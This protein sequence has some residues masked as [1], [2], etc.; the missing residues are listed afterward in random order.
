MSSKLRCAA[1]FVC[2]LVTLS[3]FKSGTRLCTAGEN[4]LSVLNPLC[5]VFVCVPV[6]APMCRGFRIQV[7]CAGTDFPLKMDS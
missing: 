2:S 5:G 6:C 7:L 1:V 4:K 3:F